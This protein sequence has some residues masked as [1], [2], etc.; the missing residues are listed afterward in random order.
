[1][2]CKVSH[3]CCLN[4]VYSYR[5]FIDVRY[6]VIS[7]NMLKNF[8]NSGIAVAGAFIYPLADKNSLTLAIELYFLIYAYD[9]PFD[10]D[11]LMLDESTATR[12]TSTFVSA[13]R[14][15]ESFHPVPNIPIILAFRE[16]VL[17]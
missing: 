13:I 15:T 16:Y 9:N 8:I 1:M 4:C 7:P 14:D 6:N 3:I 10:E 17:H 12:F 5:I 2:V 11:L